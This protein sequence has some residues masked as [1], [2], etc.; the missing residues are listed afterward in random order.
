MSHP[1]P[2]PNQSPLPQAYGASDKPGFARPSGGGGAQAPGLRISDQDR[3]RAVE[4]LGSH[5]AEGRLRLDEY[6]DRVGKASDATTADDLNALFVDLPALKPNAPLMPMYSASELE[7]ARINGRR[8][9]RAIMLLTILGSIFTTG[10][11]NPVW[12]NSG[13]LLFLIPIVAV[14]LYVL[15]IG[16]DHWHAPSQRAM[17]R[18]RMRSIRQEHRYQAELLRAERRQQRHELTHNAMNAANRGLKRFQGPRY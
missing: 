12:A 3:Q 17:E 14:L 11:L 6:E 18:A 5:F 7:R 8:P 9:K 13:F 4:S 16:P 10:I 2:F 15:K 1:A